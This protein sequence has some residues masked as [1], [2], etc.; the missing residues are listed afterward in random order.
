ML[1]MRIETEQFSAYYDENEQILFV[2]YSGIMTPDVTAQFY[3]WL[4]QS[5]AERPGLVETAR[6]SVYDFRKVARFENKNLT[7]A[8]RESQNLSQRFDVSHIPVALIVG[9]L[10]Q[11]QLLRVTMQIQQGQERKRIV[12]SVDE[13]LAFFNEYHRQLRLRQPENTGHTEPSA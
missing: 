11:E 2:T 9:S 10:Y 6:G 1:E 5:L 13:A 8:Q 3:T 7:A 4:L 12:R